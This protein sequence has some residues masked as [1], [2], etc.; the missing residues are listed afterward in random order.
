MRAERGAENVVRRAHIG[1][2]IAHGLIDRFFQRRL[3]GR[4]RHHARAEEI[5]AEVL[6]RDL[7]CWFALDDHPTVVKARQAGEARFVVCASDTGLSDPLVQLE[8][9]R[10]LV[11]RERDAAPD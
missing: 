10:K 1:H 8:L 5:H 4:Y 11:Q 6:R 7:R 3:A 9:R 2:P